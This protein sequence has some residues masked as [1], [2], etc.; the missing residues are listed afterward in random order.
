MEHPLHLTAVVL[1]RADSFASAW[2]FTCFEVIFVVFQA[3]LYLADRGWVGITY[4]PPSSAGGPTAAS[5]NGYLCPW[6][7]SARM[8]KHGADY[9]CLDCSESKSIAEG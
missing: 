1:S 5:G 8:E 7:G 6:C 3:G 2:G 4:D 9:W